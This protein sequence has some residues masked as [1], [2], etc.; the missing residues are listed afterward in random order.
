MG[1]VTNEKEAVDAKPHLL[2]G[3]AIKPQTR[4]GWGGV[5]DFLYNKKDGTFC[6]RSCKSWALITLFYC[7]YYAC[8]MGIWYGLLNVFWLTIDDAR[9]KYAS[10]DGIIGTG[11]AVVP[12]QHPDQIASSVLVFNT[13][14]SGGDDVSVKNKGA[15]GYAARIRSFLEPYSVANP[16]ATDCPTDEPNQL[17]DKTKYCKFDISTLGECATFPYG[18]APDANGN[19]NP[20]VYI[21]LNRVFDLVP[22]PIASADELPETAD[23]AVKDQLE[24]AGYPAKLLIHCQGEY[25]ADKEALADR[26]A[27][28]PEDQ[29]ISLKYFPM[30]SKYNKQ[31]AMIALQFN[32][33]PT[34]RL[35]HVICKAYY[36]GVTHSKKFRTGITTFQLLVEDLHKASAPLTVEDASDAAATPT[37]Y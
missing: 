13:S 7:V 12:G 9:P 19:V 3:T 10:N 31:N 1:V 22:E 34:N 14:Y 5:A 15:P 21:K 36:K 29:S 6:G 11:M 33:L 37:D 35:I 26:L 27:V 2:G 23:Q 8:L 16:N 32:E 30:T 18:Y 20:C 4:E 17:R 28:H 24:A 25:P